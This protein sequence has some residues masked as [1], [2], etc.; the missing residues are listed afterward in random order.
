MNERGYEQLADNDQRHHACLCVL[1]PLWG[2]RVFVIHVIECKLVIN[3]LEWMLYFLMFQMIEILL[4]MINFP[5]LTPIKKARKVHS[6]QAT[7]KQ[8]IIHPVNQEE[9]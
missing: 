4:I 1:L 9:L 7:K 5:L 8:G 3:L 6:L 2:E